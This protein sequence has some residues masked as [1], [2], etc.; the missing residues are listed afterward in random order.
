MLALCFMLLIAYYAENYAGIIDSS[1][2]LT[3]EIDP[4]FDA[5]KI[6]SCSQQL[7]ETWKW[8]QK[9]LNQF[10]N[11]W[12]QEYLSG[13][14]E[15]SQATLKRPR[16]NTGR[17]PKVG[18]VVLVKE[19]LPRGYW[20]VGRICELFLSQDKRIRSA[21]ITFG[22]NKFVNRVLSYLYPIECPD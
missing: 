18:E 4:E 13:L 12:R 2:N 5:S 3:E 9:L 6:V 10:W 7:L 16:S 22:P 21:R 17:I 8:E 20:K 11:V 15:Q 1:L 19:N 14:R